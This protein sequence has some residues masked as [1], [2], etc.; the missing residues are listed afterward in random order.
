MEFDVLVLLDLVF[1]V[2]RLL[3]VP[4]VVRDHRA[5]E[6]T[7]SVLDFLGP[8]PLNAVGRVEELLPADW[9]L[10]T[11]CQ[12]KARGRDIA[13]YSGVHN[14]SAVVLKRIEEGVGDAA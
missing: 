3:G 2:E 11:V 9:E 10:E 4:V 7:E 1:S 8:L 5:V 6:L 13:A 12:S 14:E